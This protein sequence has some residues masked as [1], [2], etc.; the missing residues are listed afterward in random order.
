MSGKRIL[1]VEDEYLI[2]MHLAVI[3]KKLGLGVVG[4]FGSLE[5]GLAAAKDQHIDMAVLDVNLAGEM[6]YP[7][8][9]AL[10]ARQVPFIFATGYD[11]S[12]WTGNAPKVSK[13]YQASELANTLAALFD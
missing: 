6:S 4:P 3:L 12:G 10:Q 2:A 8:A 9:D 11:Q 13:P 1:V 5:N 7:I